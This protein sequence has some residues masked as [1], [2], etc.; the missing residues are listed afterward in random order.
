MLS[1]IVASKQEVKDDDKLLWI[2]NFGH[3]S[4]I[5]VVTCMHELEGNKAGKI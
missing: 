3:S 1:C 5:I 4:D 2:R